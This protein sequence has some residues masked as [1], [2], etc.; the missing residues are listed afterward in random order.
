[1]DVERL[2]RLFGG[3][4]QWIMDRLRRRLSRDPTVDGAIGLAQAT[5]AQRAAAARLLGRRL[6]TG[7]SLRISLADLDAVVRS[8]GCAGSL[9]EAVVAL[10]GPLVDQAALAARTER[11]WADALTVAE[12]LLAH[13]PELGAWLER[14]RAT[15]LLRR[16]ADGPSAAQTMMTDAVAVLGHLPCDGVAISVLAARAVGDGHALDADRPLSTLVLGAAEV[17]VAEILPPPPGGPGGGRA[18]RRREVWAALG[19]LVSDLMS[20]VLTL[21]LP[22]DEA[23]VT[24][25]ALRVWRAAGQPVHLSLR[26][27][28]RD[29]PRLEVAGQTVSVCENPTVVSAAADRLGTACQPLVCTGGMPAAPVTALLTLLVNQGA[30]L[31]YHGDF[32]WGGVAIANTVIEGFGAAPWRYDGASY[33]AALRPGLAPVTGRPVT[34]RFDPALSESIG[35]HLARVEEETVLDTLLDDLLVRPDPVAAVGHR[36]TRPRPSAKD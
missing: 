6:G 5:P 3:E 34:A 2:S 29:P 9:T 14:L 35:L 26:Q 22:G 23:T 30:R 21:G 20:P 31:R 32:D 28:V 10:T 33:L 7:T 11:A 13:R 24:G 4:N 17:L 12:P 8:S 25:R 1:V 18:D 27:L 36:G 15:S 16:L 19:V